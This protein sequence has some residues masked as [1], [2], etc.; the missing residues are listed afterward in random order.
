MEHLKDA[1]FKVFLTKLNLTGHTKINIYKNV[2]EPG[3]LWYHD[4]A[5]AVTSFNVRLGLHG[6]YMIRNKTI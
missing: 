6:F 2:Q 4:H 5:M 3:T 1:T